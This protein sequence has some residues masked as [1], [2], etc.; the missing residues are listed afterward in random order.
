M[1][2]NVV[3][4][5]NKIKMPKSLNIISYNL[6]YHRAFNELDVLAKQY[7]TDFICA[8]ECYSD[9]LPRQI[10]NLH[11]ADSTKENRLGLAIYFNPKRFDVVKSKSFPLK[12]SF[13]DR[14]LAPAN[15]RLLVTKLA[16][17]KTSREIVVGSFHAACLTASNSTRRKQIIE[18]HDILKTI[19]KNNPTI[20]VGDYNYPVFRRGLRVCIEKSGYKLNF[21]DRPTYVMAKMLKAHLD[22]TTSLNAKIDQV[23]TLPKGLSDHKPILIQA[24]L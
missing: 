18:A 4:K 7:K 9:L 16:E 19:G 12:K 2:Y 11:L 21:S 8:Q 13:H 14:V 5:V 10:H 17:K 23:K 1:M 20:M 6:K 24:S 22:L 15:E 3:G